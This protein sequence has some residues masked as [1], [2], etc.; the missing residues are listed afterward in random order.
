MKKLLSLLF[1]ASVLFSCTNKPTIQQ[2]FVDNS[3]AFD[4]TSLDL[5]S[6]II[7]TEKL[8]L[9]SED[10]TALK[11]FEKI[12]VLAFKKND[13]N[14]VKYL[15]EIKKVRIILKDS[16]SYK[17]LLKV[18]SG[19]EGASVYFVGDENN[20]NEYI[21]FANKKKSGFAI[22]RV[23]G[24]DMNPTNMM[25]ILNLL[26]QSKMDVEPFESLNVIIN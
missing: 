22:L 2:Y 20:I 9:T 21:V 26:Q 24:N 23:L 8:S 18:G 17:R 11:S 13:T 16:T 14:T 25:K 10:K 19:K 15:N 12:N 7:N 4:F 3:D 5:G 1:I 6:E